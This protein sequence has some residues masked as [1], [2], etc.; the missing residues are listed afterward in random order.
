MQAPRNIEI[1]DRAFARGGRHL[2][3][4]PKTCADARLSIW[5]VTLHKCFKV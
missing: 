3:R 2:D 5:L 1:I 4:I